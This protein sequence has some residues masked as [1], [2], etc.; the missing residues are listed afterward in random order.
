V[1]GRRGR[2][3]TIL[4][5]LNYRC[6]FTQRYPGFRDRNG[7]STNRCGPIAA[8]VGA[9]TAPRR[10]VGG[11][12]LFGV[13]VLSAFAKRRAGMTALL[14]SYGRGQDEVSG[15]TELL[16]MAGYIVHAVEP[17]ASGYAAIVEMSPG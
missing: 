9:L 16:Q 15:A 1:L 4:T 3:A 13:E 5:G 6:G 8:S 14:S 17:H 7:L 2:G 12:E 10:A 11:G